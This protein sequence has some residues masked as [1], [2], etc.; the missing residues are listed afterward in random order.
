MCKIGDIIVVDKY[1]HN[2]KEIS[3]HSFVVMD[4]D[5]GEIHGLDYDMIANVMSSIKNDDQKRK[6]LAYPANFLI[7]HNDTTMQ[8]GN[9]KEAYIKTD[10]LYYFK[11]ENVSFEVIGCINIEAYKK[12]ME[13]ILNLNIDFEQIVDNLT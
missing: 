9:D 13:F 10:Q 12:L 3:K 11:K 4:I 5:N 7:K 6:K 8:K 1:I 2:G